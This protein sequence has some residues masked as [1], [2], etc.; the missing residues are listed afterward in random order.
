MKV[1][2]ANNPAGAKLGGTLS[3]KASQGVAKFSGLTLNKVGSGYTLQL[4]SS[5][6]TSAITNSITVTKNAS[7]LAPGPTAED[8]VTRFVSRATRA[9]EPGLP[10]SLVLKKHAAS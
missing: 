3:V 6:L 9:R 2:L 7:I 10:G 1:A 8:R 4:S 5:G